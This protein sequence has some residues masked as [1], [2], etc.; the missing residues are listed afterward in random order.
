MQHIQCST[1]TLQGEPQ[2][3]AQFL[4]CLNFKNQEK[5]ELSYFV[6]REAISSVA[7]GM[8]NDP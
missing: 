2:K 5:L 4:V 7:K 3:L 1:E 8:T 6:Q